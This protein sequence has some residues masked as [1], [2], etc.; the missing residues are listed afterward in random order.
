MSIIVA[1]KSLKKNYTP[2]SNELIRSSKIDDSTFRLICWMTS[3]EEGFEINFTSIQNALGY[4]R[5]KLR[6]ILKNAEIYNYLVRRKV[7]TSGGLFDFEYHIFKDT[8]DAIAFRKSL[9]QVELTPD[10]SDMDEPTRGV[11]T[12]GGRTRGGAARGGAARGGAARGGESTPLYI[13]KQLEENQKEEKHIQ[14]TLLTQELCVSE[15]TDLE[16][17][18]QDSE[19]IPQ[20]LTSL[21]TKSGLSHQIDNPSCRPT[22]AGALFD[23]NEQANNKPSKLKFQSVE[24]LLNLVLLDPGIMASDPLPAVYRSEIKLRGWRFPWRTATR[25]K[26]YQTCDRQLVELIAKER[27]KWSKCEWQEKIPTVIKSIGN[28]EATKGGLEELL[29]YWSKVVESIAPQAEESG[30]SD[31]PIGYYSNRSLDWHKATFCELLDLGDK[32]GHELAIAQFSTRYDQQHTGA[33]DGWL[34]WLS[35]HYPQMYAH[36]YP[37]AA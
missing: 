35:I 5:D 33:T 23:K 24:D 12:G 27:A 3:H 14:E 31:Q 29:G 32:V 6:K 16:Q 17:L 1:G 34:N 21:S 36:L 13:E 9:P 8:I 19:P 22:M 20:S 26:I 2:I 10:L 15:E 4:G 25:D 37:Q 28:L 30:Q 18:N 7:R 11:K